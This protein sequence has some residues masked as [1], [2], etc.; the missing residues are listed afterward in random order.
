MLAAINDT[1]TKL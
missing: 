1:F